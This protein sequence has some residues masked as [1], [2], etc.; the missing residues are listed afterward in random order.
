MW[1]KSRGLN[2][3]QMRTFLTAF[4]NAE[5]HSGLSGSNPGCIT[6]GHEWES[7]RAVHNWPSVVRVW[8]GSAVI[9]N[10][11]LLNKKLQTLLTTVLCLAFIVWLYY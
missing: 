3:F 11:N 4:S 9:V 5:W 8:P 6:T 2:I 7:H 10:K 1:R